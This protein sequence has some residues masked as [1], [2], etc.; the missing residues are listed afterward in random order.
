MSKIPLPVVDPTRTE[1]GFY[2]TKCD[3]HECTRCCHHIPGF[4]IP[5]DLERMHRHL[6]PDQD[7]GTWT[8]GHLLASPGALVMR[9]GQ[10]F[11][12]PTLVPARQPHGACIYLTAAG[13]CAIHTVSPYGCAFFDWHMAP[14]EADRRSKRG[15]QAV[16][17]AWETYDLYAQLWMVLAENG[18]VASAP[19][20]A[21]QQ[22]L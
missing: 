7:L 4:L 22:L 6:A 5:D 3:C 12:I 8:K 15:L 11:R 19:E 1:F 14:A 9:A 18:L 10:A 16:M 13:K 20:V 2:R 21:R 17:E